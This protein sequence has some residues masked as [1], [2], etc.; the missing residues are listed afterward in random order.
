ML[1]VQGADTPV[2]NGKAYPFLAV[3]PRR[4]RLR[5]LAAGIDIEVLD[6]TE[7]IELD[8]GAGRTAQRLRALNLLVDQFHGPLRQHER[9]ILIDDRKCHQK[10]EAGQEPHQPGFSAGHELAAY[11]DLDAVEC[12]RCGTGGG[13]LG[14]GT[15][16]CRD[17]GQGGSDASHKQLVLGGEKV[18]H[19]RAFPER[20]VCA[21]DLDRL[22]VGQLVEQPGHDTEQQ[23]ALVPPLHG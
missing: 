12:G 16:R 8:L 18:R 3:E 11:D 1:A 19:R 13:I 15:Q 22:D 10:H 7:V 2:V 9:S 17:R 5:I 6:P 20:G 4:Y 21:D 23:I 14:I